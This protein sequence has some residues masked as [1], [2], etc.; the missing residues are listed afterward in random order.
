ME[1]ITWTAPEYDQKK[2]QPDW[3]W[4][5]GIIAISAVIASI[6]YKNYLFAIFILLAAFLLVLLSV[7]KPETMEFEL[8]EEGIKAGDTFYSYHR[9]KSFW[10]QKMPGHYHLLLHTDRTFMPVITLPL[11]NAPE[12][13]IR[14][15]LEKHLPKEELH[16]PFTHKF[17]EFIGL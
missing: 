8:D 10:I 14:E 6:I 12:N 1:K 5:L 2:K 17:M 13:E 15:E 16:E 11:K 9:L 7:R 4:A 3:F